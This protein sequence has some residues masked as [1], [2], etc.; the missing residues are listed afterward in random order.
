MMNVAGVS[1]EFMFGVGIVVLGL[2][3]AWS[4]M[5]NRKARSHG[6][7]NRTEQATRDLYAHEEQRTREGT[8]TRAD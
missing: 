7:I 1:F 5:R 4:M 3:I 2:A 6:E 8:D